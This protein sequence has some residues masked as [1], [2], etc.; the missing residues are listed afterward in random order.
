MLG[1][2]LSDYSIVCG[3][4]RAPDLGYVSIGRDDLL[5]A[6]EEH[7]YFLVYHQGRWL[8]PTQED[9]RDWSTTSATVVTG[10]RAQAFF[11]GLYGQIFRCGSGDVSDEGAL[12]Q[13]P[14]GPATF[15]PMRSIQAIG[16]RAYAVGV[17][18]QAYRR[19]GPDQWERIDQTCRV[20]GAASHTCSFESVHG[21]H[22]EEIYAV[23]RGGGVWVFDGA[24]WTTEDCPTGAVLTDVRVLRSGVVLACGLGGTFLARTPRGWE[25][26]RHAAT[27]QDLWSLCE[28]RDRVFLSTMHDLYEYVDGTIVPVDRPPEL[29]G[30]S[31]SLTSAGDT[32][33]A[34]GTKRIAALA[35]ESWRVIA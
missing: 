35:G 6:R 12:H 5:A 4:L 16:G 17:G 24:Q 10:P 20:A 23:G 21:L 15:A 28:L 22:E 13:L 31:S 19:V 33:W 25:V 29:R 18:R 8:W 2:I 7:S 30:A 1:K 27:D 26:I 9:H 3:V 34:V 32:L 11:L 14:D